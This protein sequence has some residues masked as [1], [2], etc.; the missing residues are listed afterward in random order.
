MES[1][2]ETIRQSQG[3]SLVRTVHSEWFVPLRTGTG[4]G[5]G[6]G[7]GEDGMRGRP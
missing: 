5:T 4:T 2:R 7:T 3:S 1:N 6:P